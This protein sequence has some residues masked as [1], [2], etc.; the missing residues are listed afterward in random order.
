MRIYSPKHGQNGCLTSII[1]TLGA[2]VAIIVT[3]CSSGAPSHPKLNNFWYHIGYEY[4]QQQANLGVAPEPC[5]FEAHLQA[6]TDKLTS[7]VWS[8]EKGCSTY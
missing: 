2:I 3:G 5:S 4:A 6:G 7:A 1:V 8:F